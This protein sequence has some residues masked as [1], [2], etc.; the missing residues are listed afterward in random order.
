MANESIILDADQGSAVFLKRRHWMFQDTA[1]AAEDQRR[2][3]LL[4]F[5]SYCGPE[6][7]DGSHLRTTVGQTEIAAH[8]AISSAGRP[9]F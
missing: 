7:N 6:W 2:I 9:Q 8:G 1:G 5:A 3:E 4:D